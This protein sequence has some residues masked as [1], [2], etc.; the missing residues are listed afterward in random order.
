MKMIKNKFILKSISLFLSFWMLLASTGFS[1][2]Y[3]YCEGEIVNWSIL[4]DADNCD[5]EQEEIKSCCELESA[6]ACSNPT[7]LKVDK[8][9]CC[10][11][12]RTSM[13]LESDFNLSDR[14]VE[15]AFTHFIIISQYVFSL[16]IEENQQIKPSEFEVPLLKY[17]KESPFTQSFL[18]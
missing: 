15:F 12:D 4:T 11:S 17:R 16:E 2:N 1:V 13:Y 6:T 14:D 18:I 7:D 10:S 5:H 3:H 9:D 8:S